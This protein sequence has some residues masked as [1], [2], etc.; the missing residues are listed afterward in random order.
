MNKLLKAYLGKF[1]LIFF[2]DI[3]IYSCTWDYHLL[4]VE[5]VLQLLQ[6]NQLFLKKTKCSFGTSEVEY[7]GHIVSHGDVKVD[8]KKIQAMQEWPRPTPL[9][10]LLGFLGLTGYY[11]TNLLKKNAFHWII[12]VEQAFIELKRSMCTTLVLAMLNFKNFVFWNR[13]LQAL[14]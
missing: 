12:E 9:K 3:L 13:M 6:D 5:N 1:V 11:Q 4:H 2:D 14:V 8:P 7:L 10:R